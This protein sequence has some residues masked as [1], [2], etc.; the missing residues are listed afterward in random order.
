MLKCKARL[1]CLHFS[2]CRREVKNLS[3]AD[4]S[5]CHE[6]M[7]HLVDIRLLC[8]EKGKNLAENLFHGEASGVVWIYSVLLSR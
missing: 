6:V 2:Q 4:A 5:T 7:K 3:P 8:Q 1:F